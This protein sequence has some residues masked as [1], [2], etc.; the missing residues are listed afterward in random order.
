[1][2]TAVLSLGFL[3]A[4]TFRS[5]AQ[6]DRHYTQEQA[7]RGKVLYDTA[8]ATCHGSE[9]DGGT[10]SS[11]AGTSF[12]RRWNRAGADLSAS[13][14][15]DWGGATVDDFFFIVSTT[16]PQGSAGSLSGEEY[17]DVVAYI[18]Q[19]NGYAAGDTP[20]TS[21]SD[22]LSAIPIEWRGNAELADM[23]PPPDFIEGE[24][25][26]EPSDKNYLPSA[27]LVQAHANPR[28]WLY[29]T[30]D[31]SGRRFSDLAQI[32]T[33]NAHRLR[34]A[35][36]YQLGE[37]S[38]FQTGPIVYR[39]TMYLTTLHYTVA[40][41]AATCRPLW[42][43]EWEPRDVEVWLNNRGVAVAKGRVVRGTSDGYILALDAGDGRLLW[44]RK[45]ANTAAGET[46]TMAPLIYDDLILI[47]PAGSE[48]AVSG[49]VG[50]FR[51]DNGASVWRFE[52]VPGARDPGD[53]SWENPEDIVL[54]GGAVWTPFSFDP[55]RE[56]LYV[57]VSNPAPDFPADLR[58]GDNLYTNS[59][60]ALD[61]RSGKLRWYRQTVPNDFHDWDLTQVSPLYKSSA[62]DRPQ[63]PRSTTGPGSDTGRPLRGGTGR[64][65]GREF[66]RFVGG[67]DRAI[68][69]TRACRSFP[70]EG[71]RR[72]PDS[73]RRDLGF[74]VLR[75]VPVSTTSP[76]VP[77][78]VC[79][80]RRASLDTCGSRFRTRRTLVRGRPSRP[81]SAPEPQA[82][83]GPCTT[84]CSSAARSGRNQRTR[85]RCF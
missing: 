58:P 18:L 59:L 33:S 17:V 43:H 80:C 26:L 85:M 71:G 75:S 30:H 54:G 56:E 41:D 53:D 10:A 79:T 57:A 36:I 1:M 27:E 47:G 22:V 45:A 51:L 83:S 34:P 65:T 78:T 49:W 42:R 50:A 19:R 70:V 35:C 77:S 31:Y 68:R 81:R 48:N 3:L 29:H 67:P 15:G 9:L 23:E 55:D 7:S 61:I 2:R 20:M 62:D 14:R 82:G 72:C 44:A 39:G 66:G 63:E 84:S 74:R 46:F 64:W 60:V 76:I 6:E 25:G 16:M 8:C 12:V 69:D 32:D 73:N 4:L 37:I 24:K 13:F 11:L 28:D 21:S 5:A 52:T 40:L 38:N